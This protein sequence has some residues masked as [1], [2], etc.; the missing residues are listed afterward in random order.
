MEGD[1]GG[2]HGDGGERPP[3]PPP[4]S[5]RLVK[6][7]AMGDPRRLRSLP[8]DRLGNL[9]PRTRSGLELGGE[10]VGVRVG[11]G[12]RGLGRLEPRKAGAGLRCVERVGDTAPR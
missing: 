8:E 11:T 4:P 10:W 9:L 5:R 2:A 1:R 6:W 12:V 7:G 3:P